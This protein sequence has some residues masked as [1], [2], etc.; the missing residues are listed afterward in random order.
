MHGR[1]KEIVIPKKCTSNTFTMEW[2]PGAGKQQEFKEI[3]RVEF[4]SLEEARVKI[5]PAQIAFLE[6]VAKQI[7]F[8]Q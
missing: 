3:D 5:N 6:E 8:P 7:A 2:P 1:S 4:F